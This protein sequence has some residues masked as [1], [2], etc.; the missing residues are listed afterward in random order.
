[1]LK[2]LIQ[3]YLDIIYHHAIFWP[4]LLKAHDCKLPDNIYAGEFLSLE[5]EKMSTSKN[6]VVWISDFVK[7]FDSDLLRYYLT[8][9]APLNKDTDFSWDDFKRRNNDELA[10]VIGNFLHR[11]FTF[12]NKQFNGVIP[13]YKN[14]SIEELE[15]EKKLEKIPFEVGNLIENLKFREAL[16]EIF[17]IAKTGNKFF[18]DQEP[19]VAINENPQK[20]ANTIYL[21]NQLSKILAICLKPYLPESS[22][23]I[24]KIMNLDN[25]NEWKDASIFIPSGHKIS[26]ANPLFKKID[27]DVIE[28][29]KEKLYDNLKSDS[30]SDLISIDEFAKVD[31]RIG[32]IKEVEHIK[33]SDK[34]LKL[35]VD[36]GDKI[37]QVVAGI[38]KNY[39][40]DD[41]IDSK[42]AV[43]V[44]LEVAKLFGVK[45]EGM[46]LATGDSVALL[47]PDKCEIGEKIR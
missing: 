36:I 44:N 39:S 17:K 32:Q 27:D 16:I 9:N 13:E 40:S 10:D 15:F 22:D 3:I 33:K 2:I 41:L 8:I 46:I 18:N 11:T 29:E 38:A 19:W 30:M 31:I 42:V 34:L 24:A 5:G 35:Q 6:W 28:N 7:N 12:T 1:L 37:I 43:V 45:S 20:A 25:S 14:Q 26:K 23:K 21:S 4:S 47:H